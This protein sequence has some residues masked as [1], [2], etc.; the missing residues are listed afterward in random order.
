M[1]G[2]IVHQRHNLERSQLPR[3]AEHAQFRETILTPITRRRRGE[4]WPGSRR[5]GGRLTQ[6]WIGIRGWPAGAALESAAELVRSRLP[7]FRLS[8]GQDRSKITPEP[9]SSETSFEGFRNL[10]M[11]SA[12]SNRVLGKMRHQTAAP[13]NFGQKP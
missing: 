1:V 3:A 10:S 5:T 12:D 2:S 9:R 11:E 13:G 4:E 7:S 6:A 8:P